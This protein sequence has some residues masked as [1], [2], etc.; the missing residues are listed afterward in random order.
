MTT[1]LGAF[2]NSPA[3]R[4]AIINVVAQRSVGYPE[5]VDHAKREAKY[6]DNIIRQPLILELV[7]DAR[8]KE[9]RYFNSKN[10]CG[11]RP[12]AEA[13]A[14]GRS[15]IAVRWVD[16]N[17]GDDD[18]PNCR[19]RLV[20][21]EVRTKGD[22]PVFAPRPPLECLRTVLSLAATDIAG[23]AMHVR[24]PEGDRRT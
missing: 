24:D 12:V 15:V 18:E 10:V 21:R 2:G 13:Q 5:H 23:E 16:V 11:V 14:R 9:L 7:E 3:Q 19:G 1:G 4:P 20:A 8:Q 17:K 6:W 22:A